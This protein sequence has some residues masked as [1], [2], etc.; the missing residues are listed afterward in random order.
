VA[1]CERY[2]LQWRRAADGAR[3]ANKAVRRLQ[4]R[5]ESLTAALSEARLDT[6]CET[7]LVSRLAHENA[8]LKKKVQRLS[9]RILDLW[10]RE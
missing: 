7:G 9:L 2:E 1:A 5:V 10:S 8:E 6:R 3:S 4:A